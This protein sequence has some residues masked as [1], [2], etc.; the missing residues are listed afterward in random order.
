MTNKPTAAAVAEA[1]GTRPDV[2]E[3]VVDDD[4]TASRLL[5]RFNADPAHREL[6]AA[7]LGG[8]AGPEPVTGEG[9][10]LTNLVT[11][12]RDIERE[13]PDGDGTADA[14][15]PVAAAP[16]RDGRDADLAEFFG[17]DGR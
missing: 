1:L 16:R 10:G 7:W 14:G 11:D 4:T 13:T 2:L 9:E 6:V 8:D 17:G 3:A 15:E 5:D 12:Q